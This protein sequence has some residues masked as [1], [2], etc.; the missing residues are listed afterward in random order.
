VSDDTQVDALAS[1]TVEHFGRVDLLCNNAGI[2][3]GGRTWDIS[4][5]DWHRVL[6]VNLW[7]AIHGV[8]S[9]VP[10]LRANPDGGHVVNVAS[11]AAVNPWPAIAPYNVSKQ[12]LLALSETLKGDLRAT[13]SK[14]GV[15]VVMPGRVATGIGLPSGEA[16]PDYDLDSEDGMLSA[17]AVAEQILE[18]VEK[19]QMYLFTHPDRMEQIE[20]RFAAIMRDGARE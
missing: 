2:V 8:R 14:V 15:T 19:D 18:A 12:G 1:W 13:D 7:G 3:A 9:F 5:D 6:S 10:F 4:L 17:S 11:V 20:A 16:V